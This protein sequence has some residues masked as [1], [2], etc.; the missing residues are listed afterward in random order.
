MADRGQ[1][2]ESLGKC[3]ADV[4]RQSQMLVGR[5]GEV[6]V[7]QLI[8][9]G[10]V[11]SLRVARAWGEEIDD[12]QVNPRPDELC[13]LLDETPEAVSGTF[14]AWRYELDH[15]HDPVVTGMAN[16]DRP[17]LGSVDV[18]FGSLPYSDFRRS[19]GQGDPPDGSTAD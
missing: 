16:H 2:D 6:V 4:R 5:Q 19:R 15:C 8:P 14:V 11:D 17:C 10:L 1:L 12:D 13:G 7:N 18:R 9:D 3:T